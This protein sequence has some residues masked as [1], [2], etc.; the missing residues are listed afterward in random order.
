MVDDAREVLASEAIILQTELNA[1]KAKLEAKKQQL[2]VFAVGERLSID[3]PNLGNVSITAP[4]EASESI[5][6]IIDE[7]RVNQVD[8]LKKML[9]DKGVAREETKIIAAAKASVRIKPN[10]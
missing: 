2:R 5:K 8:G 10:I 7:D 1:I 6:L 4:R 3:V 9:I